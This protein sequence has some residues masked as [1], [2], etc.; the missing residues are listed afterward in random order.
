MSVVYVYCPGNVISGG[1]YSLHNLCAG[2]IHAGFKAGMVYHSVDPDVVN[3]ANIR[4]FQVPVYTHVDD[5][6]DNLIIVSETEISYLNYFKSIRKAVYWLGINNYFKKPP[7]RKP[8]HIKLLRKAILCR[9][10][11]G[12]SSGFIE[13]TKRRLSLWMK[14]NDIVWQP[15]I[16]HLSNSHYAAE[17]LKFKGIPKT[18]IIHNPVI[19]LFYAHSEN[20]IVKKT[21]I[22]FGPKTPKLLIFLCKMFLN[23][24]IVRLKHISPEDARLHMQEAIIFAEFGNNSG[25]DRMHREA[26]L[27]GCVIFSNTRGSA[28]VYEDMP[29]PSEYKIPDTIKNYPR[30]IKQLKKKLMNYDTCQLDFTGYKNYLREEKNNF[31]PTIKSVF[32][33]IFQKININPNGQ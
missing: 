9:N 11:H 7:F 32:T 12:Y 15:G 24:E 30:I 19:D 8:F 22:V 33:E 20:Q 17:F 23:C 16:I 31:V 29:I 21:K 26:A 18:Y 10:Y 14:K 28:A 13:N 27:L 5:K 1:V 4:S 25:R 2:L 3:H 6:T